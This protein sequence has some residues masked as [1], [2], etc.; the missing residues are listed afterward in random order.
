MGYSIPVDTAIPVLENL[1]NKETRDRMDNSDR[2]YMGAT[3]VNVTDDAKELYDIPEGAFVYKVEEGSAAEKAGIHKGD[4]IT[5]FDG[6]TVLSS[7]DLI[8]KMSYYSVG[9]TVTVE[10]QTANDGMYES[11]EVEV[12]LQE[13]TNTGEEEDDQQRSSGR[14]SQ[15]DDT[16]G[17]FNLFPFGNGNG[18]IY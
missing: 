5:K 4:I 16:D 6:E 17:S 10:V 18:K 9:E 2:G 8:E 3:V 14:S 13:G 15:D 1:I 7:S 11:R 12:T